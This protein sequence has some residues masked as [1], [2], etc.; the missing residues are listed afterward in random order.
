MKLVIERND[1]RR[2]KLGP[3]RVPGVP[4]RGA[5]VQYSERAIR[6]D[7]SQRLSRGFMPPK[8]AIDPDQI[9]Q[10]PLPGR[11]SLLVEYLMPD[12]AP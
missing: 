10:A 8:I 9:A 4:G 3:D 6:R 1:F 2:W 5:D 11:R 12:N 7:R